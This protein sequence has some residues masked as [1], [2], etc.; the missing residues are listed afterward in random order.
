MLGPVPVTRNNPDTSGVSAR[1]RESAEKIQRHIR[2]RGLKPG[3]RYLSAEE[4]GQLLGESVMTVQRAMTFLARQNILERRPKAGTF[5]GEAVAPQV[6]LACVHFLLPEQFS[7]EQTSQESCWGQVHGIRSVLPDVSVQFNFIPNQDVA[8]ARQ[9]VEQATAGGTL[10]GVILVLPSRAMR[11]YFNQSG[12]PTVVS[13]AAEPDLTNLCWLTWDQVQTGRLLASYLLERGHRRLVT[14]M[15]DI[16]SIGEHLLH[17]GIS[18]AMSAAGVAAN[19]LR[20]RSAPSERSAIT[21]LT[22]GLLG[23]GEEAPTGFICRN[24]FQADCV[25]EV[26]AELGMA[27]D[28]EVT[29]CNPPVRPAE[30]KYTCVAPEPDSHEQGRMIGQM[31]KA[32]SEGDPPE[33]RG[34]SF[35]VTLHPVSA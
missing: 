2:A 25:A 28:V 30:S 18:E 31:L 17:D 15:R 16:W 35:P 23:E 32:L 13:G 19:A 33:P 7:V 34:R 11:A 14:I 10:A 12:V 21:E 22:R 29:L 24:Q 1:V 3:E 6:G 8:F 5:V 27:G 20:V 9:V 4:A 26:I